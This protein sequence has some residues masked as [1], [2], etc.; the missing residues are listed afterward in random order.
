M[1][2]PY[3]FAP[4]SRRGLARAHRNADTAAGPLAVRPRI[5]VGLTLQAKQD[6]NAA[7]AVSGNVDLTLYG[8]ADIIGIDPRLI[9]RTDPK[10][11]V[12]NF[13]PNYLAIVD[14]DPPDFPWLLTP[15]HA[16]G[17]EHLRPWL[18]LV[19]I[20]RAKAGLPVLIGGRPLPS[21]ALKG[22]DAASELPDL[23]ESWLWA[24]TQAVSQVAAANREALSAEL[25]AYP[26]RN[27]SRLVCPRRLQPRTDYVACVVPAT[28]GGRLRGLGQP[29]A[30]DQLQ[31]AWL[32]A[33][34][35]DIELPVYF[36]WEFSTGPVGDIE[37]LARRLRTPAQYAGDAALIQQLRHIGEQPVAV[38]GDHLLFDG[39]TPGT[40][41]FE[42][43]MVSLD[44]AP[45]P[46]DA[47]FAGK[48]EAMLN[49]G[50]ASSLSGTPP[51]DHVP[52][53]SPPIYGEY[54]AKRHTVDAAK[55]SQ[56]WLDGS[57]CQPRYR[58][59]AGWGAEVVRQNQDEFMQA[60]WEQVGEVLAA[61]RALSLARL[62]RDVLKRVE[63]RHLAKLAP[64]RLLAVLAP[65]RARIRVSPTHSLHGQMASATLP[66]ELFDGSMRRLTSPR[67]S[68]FR[69]AHW[70][71]RNLGVASTAVQMTALV[72][73]FAAASHHLDAIDPNRFVPDGLLG[74][75][76]YDA[77]PLPADLATVVDLMPYTGLNIT[78]TG[79][80][81]AAIQQQ[82]ATARKLAQTTK[83]TV[84]TMD[85]VWHRGLLTETHAIRVA[86]L[87]R[88]AGQPLEGDVGHLIQQSS[89]RATE[90]VLLSVQDGAVASQALR[91]DARSG[92]LK[93]YG[94]AL[95][96]ERSGPPVR[97]A[98]FVPSTLAAVPLHALKLYGNSAVFASL[99]P[100]TLAQGAEKVSIKLIGPGQFAIGGA[101]AAGG[102]ATITMPPAAKDHA[103]LS[104]YSAAFKDYQHVVAP[105]ASS[106]PMIGAVDFPT[107]TTVATVRARANP[108]ETVPARL[109]SMLSL[110]AQTVAWSDGVLSN[111]FISTRLDVAHVELLRFLIPRTFDR[112]MYFPHLRF[113][114]SRKLEKLAPDVFL[115]G[116]GVLP[117]D[118]IMAV[119]TN[120]RFVE[121][122]MLGA[123][124]EMCRE[125]LWQGYP[126][127]NR[128]TPFQKFWQRVD[129]ENDIIP[130]HQWK[131]F[132]LGAQPAS[133]EMLVLLIR[134]Q[135]LERFPNLSIYAY[136]LTGTEKR[137]GGASPPVP[138][139]AQ[140]MHPDQI[141][142]PV[143]HGHLNKD[144]S[145]VGF[146]IAPANIATFFFVIEEH[147]TEP[148][149]GFD[150]PDNDN[151]HGATW[152]DIDWS[153][154]GVAGGEY[155]GGAALKSATPAT[156]PR[157]TNPHAATVADALLQ[158]PFRGY[159]KGQALKMPPGN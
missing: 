77:V 135:L 66:P 149:F 141:V 136:P 120:P 115:P 116:V 47:G 113:P 90:G 148:R 61:E 71:E 75:R 49:S 98:R 139:D 48:L 146:P 1:T 53:L 114:L 106:L 24:H 104:R 85:D 6:G 109:A 119:K 67:R 82:T 60:A 147:M 19:V 70:R 134:G 23:H 128:G 9:V 122:L 62:S 2:I 55:T 158:R 78:M 43:A 124:H 140:E 153:E 44:F 56:H 131:S 100:S 50:H 80:E 112:V 39:V 10:P 34:P 87:E 79:A 26:E 95:A 142:L 107:A 38:D 99:P 52:T 81:I 110:G 72:Q 25:N 137:P 102:A 129:D 91:I 65:A 5:T 92:A 7:T 8:P 4:W 74:S 68:T 155:F 157:W 64:E 133:T 154:V 101:A 97:R 11:N 108:Q 18:V 58:L 150:E 93:A 125:M 12:T 59:A 73:T 41:T 15:A 33:N 28:D 32:R 3:R 96:V 83:K 45:A 89:K 88:V 46:P 37:T 13:E 69:M 40:T 27:I 103:T 127:D 57:S 138:N 14:F 35:A 42:G 29:V 152:L 51:P 123:N 156:G 84:P 117:N 36:H 16:D 105:P 132:P 144:I 151:Q 54:P 22:A 31:P 143:M 159:W 145:Y 121:A 126:T 20:E 86:Q 21:I 17:T 30:G 94:S 63:A 130:I 118:F 76:S 111:A